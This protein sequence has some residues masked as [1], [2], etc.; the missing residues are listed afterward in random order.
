M[1]MK[2]PLF[3]KI[4]R[5]SFSKILPQNQVHSWGS[6]WEDIQQY[7]VELSTKVIA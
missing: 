2:F 4:G 1:L 7:P 6:S 3:Q 5:K